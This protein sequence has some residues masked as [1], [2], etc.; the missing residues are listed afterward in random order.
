MLKNVPRETWEE[1]EHQNICVE[2]YRC[3]DQKVTLHISEVTLRISDNF[4]LFFFCKHKYHRTNVNI[5]NII[6]KIVF[7]VEKENAELMWRELLEVKLESSSSDLISNKE[8]IVIYFLI[9]FY[10]N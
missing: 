6:G 10:V 8:N 5:V 4:F 1:S 9:S 7:T 2:A 3:I